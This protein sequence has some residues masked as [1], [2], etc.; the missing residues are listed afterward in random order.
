MAK[1]KK[2][3]IALNPEVIKLLD[4]GKYN[5]SKLIDSLLEKYF[6]NYS[7]SK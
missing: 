4:E 5:N 1:P 7:K 2:I 3:S 6:K